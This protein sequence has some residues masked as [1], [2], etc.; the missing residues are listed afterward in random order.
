METNFVS[1]TRE[2]ILFEI[3]NTTSKL[4]SIRDKDILLENILTEARQ[5]LHADA[6]S[7]YL[8]EGKDLA[9]HYAQNDTLQ[10]KMR[11]G[12]KLPFSIFSFPIDDTTMAGYAARTKQLINEP[13][14]YVISADKPYHFGKITDETTGYRTVSAL[15]MPLI[16]ISGEV[17]GVVQMLNALDDQHKP[18]SFT[19]DDE[20]FLSHFAANATAPLMHASLTREMILRMIKMAEMRDPKETGMHVH[21]VANYSVEIYDR[22]AFNHNINRNKRERF[23]DALKIAAMLHDVGKIGIPDAVLKKQGKLTYEEYEVMKNHTILGSKLFASGNS[24]VDS[25]AR[26]IALWHHE[27]WDGTGYPGHVDVNTGKIIKYNAAGTHA[28]GLI[29]TE[30]PLGARITALADVYDALCS[31]RVYKDSWDEDEALKEIRHL[32]G[33]KFDPEIVDAFF[34]ILPQIKRIKNYYV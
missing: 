12:E 22:W 26:E 17:L 21:R 15:T 11:A 8:V 9:I 32:S 31:K 19:S 34:E 30:I 14:V 18:R 1:K 20:M 16:D 29:G 23:R 3:L 25:M 5:V 28:Q 27:N 4:Y 24:F 2:D 10:S 7:I 33:S 6:G 13:D